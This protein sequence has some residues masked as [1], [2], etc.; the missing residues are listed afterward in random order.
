MKSLLYTDNFIIQDKIVHN[1]KRKEVEN[2]RG[3]LGR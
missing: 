1:K 3:T 2:S